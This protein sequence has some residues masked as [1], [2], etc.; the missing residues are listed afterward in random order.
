MNNSVYNC[1]IIELPKVHN[2]AG[3]ITSIENLKN[4]P[5]EIKRVYYLYDI[6]GGEGRGGHAHKELQQFIIAVSGAFDVLLDDGT[7][8]KI[9]HLDRSF[10]GLHVVHGIWR[11]LLNF[12]S[13][14]VC[15]V[16][17]SEKYAES[18]YIREYFNF[19]MHLNEI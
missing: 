7:N 3:N 6:P 17:A 12:S 11:E 16:L 15:L 19:K 18:D 2:R 10:Y 1:S 8:K 14:A 4:V 5:F 9:V 13:G